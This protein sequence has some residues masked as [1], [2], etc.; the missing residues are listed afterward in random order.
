MAKPVT[1]ASQL[2]RHWRKAAAV[3]GGLL[4]LFLL[5]R[6]RE[7]FFPGPKLLSVPIVRKEKVGIIVPGGGVALIRLAAALDGLR[8]P[9]IDRN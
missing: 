9:F 4:T 2:R 1:I 7:Y 5:F 6:S 8:L 3:L